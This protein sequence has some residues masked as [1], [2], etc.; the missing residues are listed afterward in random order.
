[1]T[2]IGIERRLDPGK[3]LLGGESFGLLFHLCRREAFEQRDIDPGLAVVVVEQF[4]FDPPA[5]GN[6]GIA[7]NEAGTWIAAPD[8]P[9][10]NHAPD[11]VG[12]GRIVARGHLLEDA[13][14]DFLVR[15]C[16]EGFGNIEGDIP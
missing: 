1:M 9:G 8:G 5:G 2:G 7:A 11:S 12:V 15:S 16:T 13:G 3:T 14:L 6:V 10:Q 4:T